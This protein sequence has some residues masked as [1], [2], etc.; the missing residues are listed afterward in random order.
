MIPSDAREALRRL[1]KDVRQLLEQTKDW[2]EELFL[3]GGAGGAGAVSLSG[4]R[5]NSLSAGRG[6]AR[7]QQNFEEG[8]K[9]NERSHIPGSPQKISFSSQRLAALFERFHDC[10][11]CPLGFTRN[12]LVFGVGNPQTALMFIGEGPG[13]DEDHQGEP[14]VGK[15]GQLLTKIIESI[16]FRRQ[17]VYITNIV[18]CHPMIDPA[19]PERR[20][21]D[22]PPTFEEITACRP[23]LQEQITIIHPKV[24]CT[25]GTWAAKA[26][27]NTSEGVSRLRGRWHPYPLDPTIQVMPTYHPA[28]L[29]RNPVLKKDV[30]TDMKLIRAV[31]GSAG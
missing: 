24:I 12:R 29:L 11:Q 5:R 18:K 31:L 7:A 17:D 16:G 4:L 14:F 10:V 19:Q 26:L 21:N 15:A 1:V 27:L 30:W 23:I 8:Q 9:R 22:R 13:F 6:C 3:P 20:G 28:A 25:L 2:D